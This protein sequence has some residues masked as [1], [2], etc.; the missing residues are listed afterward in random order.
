MYYEYLKLSFF[1][2]LLKRTNASEIFTFTS[3]SDLLDSCTYHA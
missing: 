3:L 2:N 1:Q